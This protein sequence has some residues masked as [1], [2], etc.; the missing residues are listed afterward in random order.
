MNQAVKRVLKVL[1]VYVLLGVALWITHTTLFAFYRIASGSMVPTV[2][3]GDIVISN[4]LAYGRK[5][6]IW[7]KYY[8]ETKYLSGKTD[9]QRGDVIIFKSP[10]EAGLIYVK[11]LV[12]VPGDRIRMT[13][14]QLYINDEPT[15][16]EEISGIDYD[17]GRFESYDLAFYKSSI[18]GKEFI[19][20]NDRDNYILDNMREINLRDDEYFVIGDNRDFSSDSRFFG[21]IH[22]KNIL[23]KAELVILSMN[24]DFTQAGVYRPK[25]ILKKIE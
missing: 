7:N 14:D 23:A 10:A 13:S 12:G 5:F 2:L 22:R 18:N 6:P 9:P 25:R 24:T 19:Y 17:L 20:M 11:R 1:G 8:G 4:E 16:R 3:V 21:P 15:L